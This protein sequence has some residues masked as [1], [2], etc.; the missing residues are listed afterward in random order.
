MF[1]SAATNISE[2]KLA[3]SFS[4]WYGATM[5]PDASDELMGLYFYNSTYPAPSPVLPVS[6]G[7]WASERAQ[8]DQAFAC[9]AAMTSTFLSRATAAPTAAASSSSS[10]SA[11]AAVAAPVFQYEFVHP[12]GATPLVNHGDEVSYV[13]LKEKVGTPDGALAEQLASYWQR[14][15]ATGDPN[16]GA[17]PHWP[18]SVSE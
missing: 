15:A 13:F 17:A 10:A 3:S 14:F 11:A 16:G 12:S 8:T 1:T 5:G 9:P 6:K 18:R 7:W 4:L 2:A